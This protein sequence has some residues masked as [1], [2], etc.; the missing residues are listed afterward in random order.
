MII[1]STYFI[2]RMFLGSYGY[3]L[4]GL[5]MSYTLAIPFFT[6]T[7]IS[8]FIFSGLIEGI[9]KLTSKNLKLKLL[10]NSK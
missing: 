5:M 1:N 7:I 2:L 9:Y 6:Y 8:T 10:T 4:K 3:S